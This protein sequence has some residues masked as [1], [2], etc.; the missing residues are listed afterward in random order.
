MDFG[1]T[2]HQKACNLKNNFLNIK[3]MKETSIVLI[4]VFLTAILLASCDSQESEVIIGTQTWSTE[5]LSVS[6]FSNG[7]AITEAE[8]DQE[9]QNATNNQT[10]AWCYYEMKIENGEKYGKLYNW[11]AV[12]DPRG[13]APKGWHIPSD[14]EWNI[15]IANLG[16]QSVAGEKMKSKDGWGDNNNGSDASGFGGLPGGSRQGNC[17]FQNNG[18]YGSWWSSTGATQFDAF[19]TML[20]FN[21]ANVRENTFGSKANGLAVRCIK[22]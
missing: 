11:F 10:P 13:L 17:P 2:L 6:A 4:A 1:S 20:S 7:D 19:Y 8:T 16:G 22:D 15:L 12:I 3:K 21:E 9:W 18:K 14:K 5:N